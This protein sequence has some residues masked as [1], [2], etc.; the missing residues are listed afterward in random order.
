MFWLYQFNKSQAKRYL[1]Y[2]QLIFFYLSLMFL[3][4]ELSSDFQSLGSESPRE[5]SEEVVCSH[6]SIL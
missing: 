6:T 2:K 4:L 5:I 1:D 3:S